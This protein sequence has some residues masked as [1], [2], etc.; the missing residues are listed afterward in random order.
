MCVVG[1][2]PPS[3]Q[4]LPP[5]SNASLHSAAH[6]AA[7]GSLERAGLY[8]MPPVIQDAQMLLFVEK[9]DNC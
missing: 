7:W 4:P 1:S 2:L 8:W 9:G 3:P 6:R 5:H